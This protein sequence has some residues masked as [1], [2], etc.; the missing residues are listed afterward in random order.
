MRMSDDERIDK[1]GIQESRSVKFLEMEPDKEPSM[2]VHR[3][4]RLLP[5][6]APDDERLQPH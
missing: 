5:L 3:V 4:N 1:E 6:A 2:A